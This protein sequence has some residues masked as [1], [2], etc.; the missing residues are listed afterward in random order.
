MDPIR[1][2]ADEHDTLRADPGDLRERG[3]APPPF[4]FRKQLSSGFGTPSP[5]RSTSHGSPIPSPSKSG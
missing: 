2:A 3:G 5:S 4:G 1:A